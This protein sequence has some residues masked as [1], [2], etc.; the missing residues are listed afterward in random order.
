MYRVAFLGLNNQ[1]ILTRVYLSYGIK[2]D[3]KVW[4]AIN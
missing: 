4:I 2:K 3:I 1:E